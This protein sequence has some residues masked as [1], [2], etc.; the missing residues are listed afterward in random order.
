[1]KRAQSGRAKEDAY[2]GDDA[3]GPTDRTARE[4]SVAGVTV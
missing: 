2:T 1:M 4:T 3:D